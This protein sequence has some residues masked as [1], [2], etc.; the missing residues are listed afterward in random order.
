MLHNGSTGRDVAQL[1]RHLIDAGFKLD[2]DGWFGDTT[3]AALTAFQRRAGLVADGIAGPKTLAALKSRARDPRLLAEADLEAAA[4]R[5]GVELAAIKAVNTVESRGHGFADN[6]YPAILYERHVAYR[7]LKESGYPDTD[8]AAKRY[9]NLIN[10]QRGGYAGGSAEWYRL[11]LARQIMEDSVA[12]GACSWGQFQIMGYHWSRLGYASIQQ[13]IA[14]MS[15][16][17]A[18]QLEAFCRFIETDPALHKALK[19]RKWAAFASLYNGPAYKANL[20][21]IKLARAF[22]RYSPA[23]AEVAA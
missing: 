10:P 13:F 11:T 15:A 1:Q 2:A 6:G 20:Y 18:A 17:E 16:S 9:P 8:R 22:D 5:L 4:A 21:D 12:A 14:E 19:A 7:L 3:E 23:P